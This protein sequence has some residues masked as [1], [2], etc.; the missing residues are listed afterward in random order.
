MLDCYA[1]IFDA[2]GHA[3]HLAMTRYPHARD[4][5]FAHLLRHVDF[6]DC[7]VLVDAPSGG[8]Y[9]RRHLPVE[10]PLVVSVEASYQ[11]CHCGKHNGEGALVSGL[12]AFALSDHAADVLVSLAGLHHL[13]DRAAFYREAKRVLRPG[14][15]IVVADVLK[16]SAA[17][18]FL[19]GFVN[20]A[21][22]MG[23][24]GIFLDEGDTRAMQDS[25]LRIL[26][27]EHETY[28]WRFDSR[29]EMADFC[30]LLFGIDR[31]DHAAIASAI[32]EH[33][34]VV[35]A[36]DSVLMNWS[37]QFITADR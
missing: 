21:N 7:D 37:L 32:D 27:V 11:F 34:G 24:N 28:H 25:G 23:H 4:Q 35:E 36:E 31:A 33:V 17:D 13:P 10:V 12:P 9:L 1:D 8:G 30:K 16:G 15:R 14:G 5:E 20:E 3:Y 2:R 6:R 29:Y 26:R 22:S 19:N 18:S